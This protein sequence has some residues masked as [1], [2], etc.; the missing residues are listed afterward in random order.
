M[1]SIY[2]RIIFT[3]LKND[4]LSDKLIAYLKKGLGLSDMEI[5]N[6]LLSP[7]RVLRRADKKESAFAISRLV[8]EYGGDVIVEPVEKD[9]SLPFSITSGN[10]R[11]I[12]SEMKKSVMGFF[13]LT[14]IC[15]KIVPNNDGAPIPSLLEEGWEEKIENKISGC[16]VVLVMDEARFLVLD[17]LSKDH[18]E[19]SR[20]SKFD[21]A[22]RDLFGDKVSV[23]RGLALFPENGTNAF[24]LMMHGEK[25]ASRV[26]APQVSP[27]SRTDEEGRLSLKSIIKDGET[28]MDLFQQMLIGSRGKAFKW[29]TERS[30][31]D[32]WHGLGHLPKVRQREFLY[33]LPLDSPLIPG[34]EEAI[35]KKRKPETSS[36]TN[37]LAEEMLIRLSGFDH[38]G[39]HERMKQEIR[40]DLKK[41]ESFPTL[42]KV[43]V[44]IMDIAK[45]PDSSLEELSAVIRNDPALT[46]SI[47]KMVNS[48]YYGYRQ[49]VDSIER[50]VV[51]LGRDEIVNLALGLGAMKAIDRSDSR[52]LY[53]PKALWHHLMGTALICRF[54]YK[55]YNR[56]DDPVLFTAGLLHDFG[57]I[58]LVEHYPDAYGRLHLESVE[59]DIPLYELEEE[60]FG[61]NHAVIGKHLGATW[62]LPEPLI[63]AAAFHHQPFFATEHATLAA[64]IGFADFLYHRCFPAEDPKLAAPCSPPRLT[65][66]HWQILTEACQNLAHDDMEAIVSDARVYLKENQGIFSVLG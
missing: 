7:P 63:Q 3:G 65:Y 56:K 32:L 40:R 8:E 42:S 17:F 13:R 62:N 22:C 58:F 4:T 2:Y 57:K 49:K 51:I 28:A 39:D 34:L 41:V 44:A 37:R 45:K 25:T 55:R 24:E 11:R 33:R 52:G 36:S 19:Y 35:R 59:M 29:L 43:V 38:E 5:R 6:I 21:E 64:F 30:L 47:L 15:A 60:C 50:A 23:F 18:R 20:L 27:E 54:L 16:A 14:L 26:E 9:D 12:C 48:A 10:Y 31:D 61:V 66:G 46:L 53:Q 1:D